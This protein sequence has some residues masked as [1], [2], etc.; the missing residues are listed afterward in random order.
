MK[1]RPTSDW[2]PVGI[3]SHHADVPQNTVES[4]STR[5]ILFDYDRD[6]WAGHLFCERSASGHGI[7]GQ[8][9]R[10]TQSAGDASNPRDG[11]EM[12]A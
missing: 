9:S 2:T 7:Q 3:H 10:G 12:W 1:G 5:V 4:M 11:W 6:G 8:K